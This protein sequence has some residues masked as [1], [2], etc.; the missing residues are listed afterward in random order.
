MWDIYD[1]LIAAVPQELR[2]T[3]CLAGISW[4]MVRSEATGMAMTMANGMEPVRNCG[5]LTGMR[6]RDLRNKSI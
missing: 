5:S 1:S 6:V 4:I 3:D 2:V